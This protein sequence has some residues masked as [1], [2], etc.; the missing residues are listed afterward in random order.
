LQIKIEETRNQ[1]LRVF[2]RG[3]LLKQ[4]KKLELMR[5]VQVT[6]IQLDNY[7]PW[8]VTPKPRPESELQVLQSRIYGELQRRFSAL[9]G[10]VFLTRHDNLI[11]VSNGLSL[12]DHR[13]IL[14]AFARDFPV[15]ASMGVGSGATAYE[16]QVQATLA[17][18]SR[19]SSRS[20]S[21]RGIVAGEPVAPPDEAWV[22]IAHA[23]INHST[24]FTDTKP[25]YDTHLLIQRTHLS[26]AEHMAKHR[27][28]VFY[29]G[30]D[31]FMLVANGATEDDLKR[32]FAEVKR[33][34]G[35]ELKA[36]VGEAP[37][38]TEAAK[39]AGEALQDIRSGRSESSVLSKRL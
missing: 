12:A 14:N 8:T 17:L 2:S 36:G 26:L 37:K 31:N 34:L 16:A 1:K 22:K 18:Q 19:G 13:E 15:T 10:M 29:L 20:G 3:I 38:A 39:L 30:G 11:A 6:V 35:V 9:G 32:V 28:L 23:D 33:E 24:L 7:G 25:I 4:A 21:R 27:A 5:K